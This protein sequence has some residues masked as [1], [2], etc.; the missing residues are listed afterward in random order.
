MR[1][2]GLHSEIL[3]QKKKQQRK[4]KQTKKMKT[5]TRQ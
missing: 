2:A 4:P 5:V 3:S 1:P